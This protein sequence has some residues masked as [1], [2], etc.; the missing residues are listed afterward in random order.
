MPRIPRH[1]DE[2][3]AHGCRTNNVRKFASALLPLCSPWREGCRITARVALSHFRLRE[4]NDRRDKLVA[5]CRRPERLAEAY[6]E[7]HPQM[8]GDAGRF[9]RM[10]ARG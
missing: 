10:Y 1:E 5:V 9:S 6:R 8:R 4:H 2:D 3:I 7:Q